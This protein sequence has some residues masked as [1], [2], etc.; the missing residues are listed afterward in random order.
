MKFT[1][2]ALLLAVL[3]ASPLAE[4]SIVS[5]GQAEMILADQTPA[6]STVLFGDYETDNCN[7]QSVQVSAVAVAINPRADAVVFVAHPV[8][9][10]EIRCPEGYSRKFQ[11]TVPIPSQA[12]KMIFYIQSSLR[13]SFPK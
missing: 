11:V 3:A 5:I 1:K 13:F 9:G 10:P 8:Y 2:M 12:S 6:G 7:I 4:A